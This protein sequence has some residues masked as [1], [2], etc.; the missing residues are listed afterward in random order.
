MVI[1]TILVILMIVMITVIIINNKDDDE[2]T[3]MI[4]NKKKTGKKFIL[5]MIMITHSYVV[6]SLR[7]NTPL[8]PNTIS[9]AFP[10]SPKGNAITAPK[11]RESHLHTERD[12]K[13]ALSRK[14]IRSCKFS[15][16]T[17]CEKPRN[18]FGRFH[19]NE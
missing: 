8:Y 3:T 14:K 4:Q 17:K 2:M 11:S 1:L 5:L 9:T 16:T 12:C 19:H 18:A 15:L 13:Q 10:D 6:Q 7:S